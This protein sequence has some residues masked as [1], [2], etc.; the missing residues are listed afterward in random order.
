MSEAESA[1]ADLT[2]STQL[3]SDYP[4]SW[5]KMASVH[6]ELGMPEEAFADFD[7]ALAID[8]NDADV[9]V[10]LF[11]HSEYQEVFVLTFSFL[12]FSF[13]HRGQVYFITGDYDRAI[14][15][16]KRSAEIDPVFIFS[17]IQLAVAH[18]KNGAV[19]KALHQFKKFLT[20]FEDSAEV[21]NYYGELLLDQQQFE[22]AVAMFDKSI[23]LDKNT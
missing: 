3:K 9:L 4:V 20:K 1:L 12:I 7:R 18:Y 15:E 14:T 6:M 13:Y 5:V 16:Y 10:L 23:E 22:E 2:R 8:P 17:H 11:Y 19:E 21:F